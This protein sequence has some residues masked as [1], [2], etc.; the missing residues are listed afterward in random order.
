MTLLTNKYAKKSPYFFSDNTQV[1]ARP[2]SMGSNLG[3]YYQTLVD[4]RADENFPY[5]WAMYFSSDHATVE[6]TDGIW[7]FVANGDPA[8]M[9]WIDYDVALAAG[10][11]DSF[12]TKPAGN[13]I[14]RY[15]GSGV[16]TETPLVIRHNGQYAL[17]CQ[18]A[19]M[20]GYNEQL[21][22]RA[23]SPDGLN[24]TYDRPVA[25]HNNYHT[26]YIRGALNP[27]PDVPFDYVF[28]G[29][30][31][32]G[33][34]GFLAQWGCDDPIND[35]FTKL[36]MLQKENGRMVDDLS[37]G[38]V[39]KW[40]SCDVNSVRQIG[41]YYWMLISIGSSS[42]G[43]GATSETLYDVPLD[44]TGRTIVGKP[45]LAISRGGSGA[46][47]EQEI[48]NP[49]TVTYNGVTTMFYQAGTSGNINSIGRAILT[50]TTP[51][52]VTYPDIRIP[53]ILTEQSADFTDLASLP[54]WLSTQ[55]EGAT[56]PSLSFSSGL[57]FNATSGSPNG[58]II[59]F[60]DTGVQLDTIDYI[61]WWVEGITTPSTNG[62]RFPMLGLTSSKGVKST[63]TDAIYFDNLNSL[64]SPDGKLRKQHRVANS[65]I[66]NGLESTR[67]FGWGYGTSYAADEPKALGFRYF[68]TE[69]R[70][71][72]IGENAQECDEITVNA[73]FDLSL[74]YYPFFG[75]IGNGTDNQERIAK[76]TYKFG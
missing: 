3:P 31:G 46:F 63:W 1:I 55:S 43:G 25:V 56:P 15:T 75:I 61:E 21:T 23:L 16:Q 53:H 13:P 40:M 57:N 41:P 50:D 11:F 73:G 33:G 29:L 64:G 67:Y 35:D 45:I 51:V 42:A 8:T 68:P 69:G 2:A 9:E 48:C 32:D 38:W 10:G 74:T 34:S 36:S 4:M 44:G 70:F 62:N 58:Q 22:F 49:S 26:G 14:F 6:Q 19:N 60:A 7:L 20:S 24:F 52:R 65:A 66:V 5:D 28:Y 30:D 12:E 59:M 37:G 17:F 27:F 76:L 47:D 72:I 54:A 71:F 18:Q 39:V